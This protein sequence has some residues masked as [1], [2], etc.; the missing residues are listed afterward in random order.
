MLDKDHVPSYIEYAEAMRWK[1]ESVM[2][3]FKPVRII[4]RGESYQLYFYKPRGER[5]R[6]SIGSDYHQAQR[7]AVR[8]SDWLMDGKD[9]EFEM[10]RNKQ[11]ELSHQI[12][13]SELY[14]I[15][16][17]RHGI[18]QSKSMQKLY[19][20]NFKNITRCPQLANIPICNISKNLMLDYMHSRI[21]EDG[22]STAT[23][24]R[25]A[26]MVKCM[27]FRATDWDILENNPLQG[28]KLLPEAKKRDVNITFDEAS[29]LLSYLKEPI[30]NIVEFALY[31][32]FRKESILSLRIEDIR[33]HD[34]PATDEVELSVKGGKREIFPL[35][36]NAVNV[37]KRAIG[38]KLNGYVFI[39]PQTQT[40]Y[41]SIL[42]AFDRAVRIADLTVN[43][44]K[45]RFHDIRHVFA[46]TLVRAGVSLESIRLM[47]GHEDRSTTDR[48][49]TIDRFD[50]GNVLNFIPSARS[51]L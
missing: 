9:P 33:F 31:T 35:S 44:T 39:N 19:Y 43:G 42:K 14:P 3:N 48:Y 41:Y 45:F 29:T 8:F 24:N 2:A 40:R 32:G 17:E 4:K 21:K 6:L 27:L 1:G 34:L 12:T 23:V 15:F 46:N 51:T 47:L 18:H 26:S 25:E 10:E 13:L 16:M 49:I 38:N 50:V 7:M 30:A 28:L 36:S 22:V 11:I 20:Y 37:L 5:R